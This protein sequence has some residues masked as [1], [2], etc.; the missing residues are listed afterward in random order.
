MIKNVTTYHLN[1]DTEAGKELTVADIQYPKTDRECQSIYGKYLWQQFPEKYYKNTIKPDNLKKL[2]KKTGWNNTNLSELISDG[3]FKMDRLLYNPYMISIDRE[4]VKNMA[5]Y[6]QVDIQYLLDVS[7]NLD[8]SSIPLAPSTNKRNY[9]FLRNSFFQGISSEDLKKISNKSKF[10]MWLLKKVATSGKKVYITETVKSAL[11]RAILSETN[12]KKA[13]S[14]IF[15]KD[16]NILKA[17]FES[18]GI[19]RD[20]AISKAKEVIS[21]PESKPLFTKPNVPEV[22]EEEKAEA[23]EEEVKTEEKKEETPVEPETVEEPKTE[24]KPVES[25]EKAETPVQEEEKKEPETK[26]AEGEFKEAIDKAIAEGKVSKDAKQFTAKDFEASGI[27]IKMPLEYRYKQI[28]WIF[29]YMNDED[30]VNC[31]DYLFKLE[32][33]EKVREKSLWNSMKQPL[34]LEPDPEADRINQTLMH[35]GLFNGLSMFDD[36]HLTKI[37]KY[38]EAVMKFREEVKDYIF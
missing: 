11:Y 2:I 1:K 7:Y 31:L 13:E 24:E 37:I 20:E 6:L 5:Y 27:I 17:Y 38:C 36:E 10:P 29:N 18:L 26:E 16:V 15:V 19:D 34:N 30:L 23:K 12:L 4:I 35:S 3:S 28:K 8:T 25:E 9:L 22:K 21:D 14:D 32:N 33:V